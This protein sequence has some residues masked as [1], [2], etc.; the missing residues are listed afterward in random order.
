M[1]RVMLGFDGLR[2]GGKS[3]PDPERLGDF[4]DLLLV[5][6]TIVADGTGFTM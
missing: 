5:R 6:G 3:N 4:N 1:L 2:K